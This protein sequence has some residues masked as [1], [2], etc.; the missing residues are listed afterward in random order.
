MSDAIPVR[1]A[2]VAH[3]VQETGDVVIFDQKGNR[4]LLL[5]DVGAAVWLLVDGARGAREIARLI[6]ETLPADPVQVEGDVQAFLQTLVSHG[7]IELRPA[8]GPTPA[9]S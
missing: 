8:E 1:I 7:V 4:L 6:T 3:E 2:S 9:S 5:N